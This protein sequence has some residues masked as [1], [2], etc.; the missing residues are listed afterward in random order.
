MPAIDPT[1]LPANLQPGAPSRNLTPQEMQTVV[2]QMRSD[3]DKLRGPSL[4]GANAAVAAQQAA[5]AARRPDPIRD[6][7]GAGLG[8]IG[9][10]YKKGGKVKA[11]AK[12]GSVSA[13]RRA[14]GCAQR[15]KTRGTMR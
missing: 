3:K 4:A 11:Y 2:A 14:D 9:E 13:S 7:G 10:M 1:S 8:D 6:T 5:L 12:G 15:G